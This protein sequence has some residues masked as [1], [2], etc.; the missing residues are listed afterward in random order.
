VTFV[1]VDFADLELRVLAHAYWLDWMNMMLGGSV[2]VYKPLDTG[3]RSLVKRYAVPLL[4]R[5]L[6][7]YWFPELALSSIKEIWRL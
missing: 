1:D 4:N 2:V 6:T 7:A 3:R 5:S